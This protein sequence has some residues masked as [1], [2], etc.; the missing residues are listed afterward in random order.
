[1]P[2]AIINDNGTLKI[3]IFTSLDG[4]TIEWQESDGAISQSLLDEIAAQD[5]QADWDAALIAIHAGLASGAVD[6]PFC[7]LDNWADNDAALAGLVLRFTLAFQQPGIVR[8][9][10]VDGA[11]LK[12]WNTLSTQ[13]QADLNTTAI[14][15]WDTAHNLGLAMPWEA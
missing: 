6:C 3:G 8:K 14:E 12:L 4:L 13:Q 1:M 5:T 11:M 7:Q 2:K 10:A 15:S 9:G